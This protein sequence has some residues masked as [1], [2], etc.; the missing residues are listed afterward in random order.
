MAD[1]AQTP[2]ILIVDDQDVVVR[3]NAI[4]LRRTGAEVHTANNGKDAL[5]LALRRLPDVIVMDQVMPD[6]TGDAVTRFI[7]ARQELQH[8]VIVIVTSQQDESTR[9]QCM[10][11]GANYYVT[12]PIEPNNLLD[13]IRSILRR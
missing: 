7:R 11:A 9:R 10:Q 8:T 1:T 4:L 12:K 3:L 5:D 2:Q 6:M 13:L